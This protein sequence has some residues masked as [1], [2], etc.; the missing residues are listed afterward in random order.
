MDLLKL[1]KSGQP[2]STEPETS[3][4]PIPLP[5]AFTAPPKR[6][7]LFSTPAQAF[8]IIL[9]LIVAAGFTLLVLPQPAVNSIAKDIEERRGASRQEKISFLYMGDEVLNNEL[10]LRGAIRN[11]TGE[12]LEKLDAA[13][14]FYS[15][16][17]SILETIIVR[18]DKDTIAPDAVAQ[19]KVVYPNY[20]MEFASYSVEFKLR[21]GE[22]VSYKDLRAAK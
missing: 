5:P 8:L 16:D 10:H 22:F 1:D 3:V 15:Q 14:R 7:W 17:G 21:R 2:E 19:F 6:S 12:P 20:K 18:M 11:I 4:E 13:V 9:S